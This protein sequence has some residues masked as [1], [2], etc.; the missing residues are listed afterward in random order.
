MD[1]MA[2]AADLQI[3]S[4]QSQSS[5]EDIIQDLIANM[6]S[7]TEPNY[8]FQNNRDLTFDNV[9]P[10]WGLAKPSL[11]NGS[12]YADLDNDGDLDLVVNEVNKEASIYRNN[13][14]QFTKN[15]YLK[16][17]LKGSKSNTFGIGSKVILFVNDQQI[18]QTLM[19]S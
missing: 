12:A 7:I 10:D 4:Q 16:I 5:N 11:S 6:P 17:K 2:Y 19:L 14:E 3:K 1:F 13:A 15:N 8:L 9:A 18:T